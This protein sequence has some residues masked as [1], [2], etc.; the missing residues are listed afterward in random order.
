MKRLPDFG[1]TAPSRDGP[2]TRRP[3][4]LTTA[5]LLYSTTGLLY[6]AGSTLVTA[7]LLNEGA[8]VELVGIRFYQGSYIARQGFIWVIAA[9][10][11]FALVGVAHFIAGRLLWRSRRSGVFVAVAAFPIVMGLCIGGEA[12]V[13]LRL[14][15]IKLIFVLVASGHLRS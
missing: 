10:L 13:A 14:E 15:P 7:L 12:P 9:T 5:S 8:L 11:T 3:L 4:L 6:A 1:G 2:S